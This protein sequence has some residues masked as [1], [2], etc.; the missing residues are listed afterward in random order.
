MRSFGLDEAQRTIGERT[1]VE[2]RYSLTS[3][4]GDVQQFAHAVRSHWGIENGLPWVLDAAFREDESRLRR[5]HGAQN[6]AVLRHLALSLLRQEKTARG[7][8]KSNGSKRAGMTLLSPKC[9]SQ[10]THMRLPWGAISI[11]FCCSSRS[12]TAGQQK[13]G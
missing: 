3:L 2:R 6:F 5:D 4:A 8:A 13:G 7:A 12:D 1:T 10:K 11:G 9:S